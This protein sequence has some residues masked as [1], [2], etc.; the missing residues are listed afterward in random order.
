MVEYEAEDLRQA[1]ENDDKSMQHLLTSNNNQTNLGAIKEDKS[2]DSSS[3]HDIH[4]E[5]Q[6]SREE[7]SIN[8]EKSRSHYGD[9][10]HPNMMSEAHSQSVPRVHIG[11]SMRMYKGRKKK[12]C[13][14]F[15]AKLD[16]EILRPLLIYNYQRDEM[17]RQAEVLD[18]IMQDVNIIG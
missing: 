5:P 2:E 4:K 6:R 17:H 12:D 8:D 9:L 15:M 10:K 16:Y 18:M 11:K 3:E 7:G 1:S 14:Y 13:K